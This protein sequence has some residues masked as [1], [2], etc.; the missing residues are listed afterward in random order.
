M[1]HTVVDTSRKS[2]K[3]PQFSFLLLRGKINE[4][5]PHSRTRDDNALQQQPF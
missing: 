1:M 5:H 2:R 4:L 3:E